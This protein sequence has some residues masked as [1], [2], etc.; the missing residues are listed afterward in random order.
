MIAK[1]STAIIITLATLLILVSI[2]FFVVNG[3][4]KRCELNAAITK[5]QSAKAKQDYDLAVKGYEQGIK[6]IVESYE[7]KIVE[8][9]VFERRDDET[10]CEAAQRL[11]D[12]TGY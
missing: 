1:F 2:G 8:V 10:E 7:K 5:A 6:E 12:R 4:K 3:Q 9:D 11:F